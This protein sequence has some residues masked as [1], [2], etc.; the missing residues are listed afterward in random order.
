VNIQLD[1]TITDNIS[2]ADEAKTLTLLIRNGAGGAI[3][4]A[5]VVGDG[6][7]SRPVRMALDA[8]AQLV[9]RDLIDAS[10]TL[11]YQAAPPEASGGAVGIA[12][13]LTERVR[14]YLQTGR[15][16]LVSRSAD[17][18]TN[19]IVTVELTATIREP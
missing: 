7:N 11:E 17:P 10:L 18:V 14:I 3:R 8:T 19:R 13:D 6:H 9:G 5:G 15:R 2:G 1:V 4:T 16:F 12:P